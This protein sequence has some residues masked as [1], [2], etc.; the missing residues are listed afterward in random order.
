V[1]KDQHKKSAPTERMPSRLDEDEESEP[2][3]HN[4]EEEDLQERTPS[5][6]F[7]KAEGD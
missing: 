6:G 3:G 2:D 4:D 1:E 7:L 5:R